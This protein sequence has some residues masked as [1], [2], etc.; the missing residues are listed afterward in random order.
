MGADLAGVDNKDR[1]NT[2]ATAKRLDHV[3][4]VADGVN[5]YFVS[6]ER[7]VWAAEA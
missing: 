6:T 2:K 1:I 3:H 4:L 5:G 7:G